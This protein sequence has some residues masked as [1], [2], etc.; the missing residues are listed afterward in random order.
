MIH[1]NKQHWPFLKI[2][3][4]LSDPWVSLIS[5]LLIN[6]IISLRQSPQLFSKVKGTNHPHNTG[7]TQFLKQVPKAANPWI[8]IFSRSPYKLH[9]LNEQ[10]A[11]IGYQMPWYTQEKL[12]LLSDFKKGQSEANCELFSWFYGKS[13]TAWEKNGERGVY[14]GTDGK[15]NRKSSLLSAILLEQGTDIC[16]PVSFPCYQNISLCTSYKGQY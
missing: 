13:L 4:M 3:H 6:I 8:T 14:M 1:Q 5:Q 15:A 16:L 7:D 10:E 11:V 12:K 9:M 2:D